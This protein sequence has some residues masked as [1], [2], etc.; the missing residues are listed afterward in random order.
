METSIFF[1][2]Q[3]Q[4]SVISS[5]SIGDHFYFEASSDKIFSV[6]RFQKFLT[7]CFLYSMK[8]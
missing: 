4:H 3:I 2:F 7:L 5:L 8:I 1:G 6:L